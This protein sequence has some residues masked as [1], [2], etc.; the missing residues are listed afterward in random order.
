M[1]ITLEMLCRW[2]YTYEDVYNAVKASDGGLTPLQISELPTTR[3]RWDARIDAL[4]HEDLLAGSELR[5]LACKWAED[6][7]KL[8]GYDAPRAVE[9]LAV[10]RAYAEGK[11][12]ERDLMVAGRSAWPGSGLMA[13][14]IALGL[15]AASVL[16]AVNPDVE[17]AAS[18]VAIRTALS[19]G[20]FKYPE[21]N[22]LVKPHPNPC[23]PDP[24]TNDRDAVVEEAAKRRMKEILIAIDH[25]IHVTY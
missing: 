17:I 3:T 1:K 13:R 18:E 5:L 23:D 21:L 19:E 16:D 8:V 12:T 6:A 11:A 25:D 22:F 24:C 9:A 20:F 7:C 14:S 2:R 4:C 15:A 10:S